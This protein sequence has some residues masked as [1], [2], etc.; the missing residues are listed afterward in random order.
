MAGVHAHAV[1]YLPLE[2][3][4]AL[5]APL[6]LA[7]REGEDSLPAKQFHALLHQRAGA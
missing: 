5:D 4:D 7:W 6:T 3:C 2:G 1:A